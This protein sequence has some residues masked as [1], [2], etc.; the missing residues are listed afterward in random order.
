MIV[1][2]AGIPGALVWHLATYQR[3]IWARCPA[4]LVWL[5][6]FGHSAHVTNPS[7]YTDP[8]CPNRPHS[9]GGGCPLSQSHQIHTDLR[10]HNN[11]VSPSLSY[12]YLL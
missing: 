7:A 9:G 3:K 1:G 2:V 6:V 11:C 12:R 8:P 10:L 4:E 5:R